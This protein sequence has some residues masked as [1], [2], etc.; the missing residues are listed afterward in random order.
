MEVRKLQRHTQLGRT[1]SAFRWCRNVE[2]IVR[3]WNSAMHTVFN[4]HTE[5][6]KSCHVRSPLEKGDPRSKVY[7]SDADS[8]RNG[9]CSGTFATVSFLFPPTLLVLLRMIS[10]YNAET[11]WVSTPGL[12]IGESSPFWYASCSGD[13]YP[14]FDGLSAA[15]FP[16]FRPKMRHSAWSD[17]TMS[18][19]YSRWRSPGLTIGISSWFA[20][21]T[22]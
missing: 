6:F 8:I 12:L 21:F 7:V 17:S 9:P 20:K 4:S 22:C 16:R 18:R 2:Y 11:S 19:F 15:P 10:Q 14:V 1:H 3:S 5:R 13:S